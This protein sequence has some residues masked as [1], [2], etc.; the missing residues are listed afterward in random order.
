MNSRITINEERRKSGF[1]EITN[2]YNLVPIKMNSQNR[3]H[4][5]RQVIN[6]ALKDL[7]IWELAKAVTIGIETATDKGD[8]RTAPILIEDLVVWYEDLYSRTS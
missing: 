2:L 8:I 5:Y 3:R 4:Y 7:S 6:L 1:P